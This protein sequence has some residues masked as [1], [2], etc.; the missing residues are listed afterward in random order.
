LGQLLVEA[1]KTVSFNSGF[2]PLY[3]SVLTVSAI[4]LNIY[5]IKNSKSRKKGIQ[6]PYEND[7]GSRLAYVISSLLCWLGMCRRP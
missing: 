3:M 5:N 7:N 4:R 2:S 1:E 6:G